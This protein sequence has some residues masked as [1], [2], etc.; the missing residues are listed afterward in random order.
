MV[1]FLKSVSSYLSSS[2]RECPDLSSEFVV[3][4]E[5]YVRVDIRPRTLRSHPIRHG[6][7]PTTH[8][9]IVPNLNINSRSRPRLSSRRRVMSDRVMSARTLSSLNT[10]DPFILPRI[11]QPGIK[12][13]PF[14]VLISSKRR[15]S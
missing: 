6:I 10:P 7:P 4:N 11:S 1:F 15:N 2:S 3:G 14:S 8:R 9:R 12:V 13:F 5:K